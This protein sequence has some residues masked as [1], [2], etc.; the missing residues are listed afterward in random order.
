MKYLI[1]VLVLLVAI[2]VFAATDYTCVSNCTSQGYL[3]SYCVE[4]CS[5]EFNTKPKNIDYNC[6]SDC[7]AKGYLYNYCTD[8]CSY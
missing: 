6:V 8:I 4:K 5:Y 2:P 1:V 3:Y 7:T